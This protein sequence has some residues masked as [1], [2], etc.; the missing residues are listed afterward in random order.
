M[1]AGSHTCD[2]APQ[3][4]EAS[5][6]RSNDDV[7]MVLASY[8]R[9]RERGGF[10]KSFYQQL[11]ARDATIQHRFRNTDMARQELIM[12]EAIN[13]LL[14]FASGSVV[15][16]MG[17]DRIAVMHDHTHHAVPPAVYSLFTEVLID[18][19]RTWDPRWEPRLE[20]QWRAA[21]RPGLDYMAARFSGS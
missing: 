9:C 4:S 8:A 5:D 14:M 1:G 18:T 13:T 16:R 6:T 2:P 21:L 17:L 15:A 11:W 19:A 3:M 20:Q 12:R 7:Q 10:V